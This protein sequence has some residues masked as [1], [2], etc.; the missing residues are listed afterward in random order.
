ME[1]ATPAMKLTPAQALH[2][3]LRS[4]S[5]KGSIDGEQIS[6]G[7]PRLAAAS[8]PRWSRLAGS[9]LPLG[10][11]DS[12]VSCKLDALTGCTE[13]Q[14]G[15]LL[16]FVCEHEFEDGAPHLIHA[17]LGVD[18]SPAAKVP[19]SAVCP[20]TKISQHKHLS[21]SEKHRRFWNTSRHIR[22]I[23][24]PSKPLGHVGKVPLHC[25]A[26]RPKLDLKIESIPL[27][28]TGWKWPLASQDSGREGEQCQAAKRPWNTGLLLTS[29]YIRP[30]MPTSVSMDQWHPASRSSSL[31]D[32]G[33]KRQE[34]TNPTARPRS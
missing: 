7:P 26:A 21:S 18:F 2:R 24:L 22:G 25:L 27:R 14:R 34:V 11:H 28:L 13:N 6:I 5:V 33:S 32:V 31:V 16:P 29:T 15:V 4:T 23:F 8:L 19:F 3:G 10:A 30:R 20:T 17:D 1:S 12:T 9:R